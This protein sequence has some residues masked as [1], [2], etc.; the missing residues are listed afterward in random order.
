MIVDHYNYVS[1]YVRG[2]G[3][4][5]YIQAKGGDQ[6]ISAMVLFCSVWI[7]FG[8]NFLFG[9]AWYEEPWWSDF[10]NNHQILNEKHHQILNEKKRS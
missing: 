10:V 4:T 5:R 2:V 8:S 7:A 1:K 9:Q 3:V 6:G